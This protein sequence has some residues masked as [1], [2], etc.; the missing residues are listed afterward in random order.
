MLSHDRDDL[1]A[2]FAV[3]LDGFECDVEWKTSDLQVELETCDTVGCASDLE[4]HV[5]EVVFCAKDI[6][7]DDVLSDL[8][9]GVLFSNEASGDTGARR[10]DRHTCIHERQA[11]TA[12]GSHRS[13]AVR[14]HDFRDD[15]DCVWELVFGRK[16]WKE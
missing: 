9:V 15:A 16:N 6:C 8:A 10:R 3:L 7:Q 5:A 11:T 12:D 13:G 4:V 14:A 1:H 2:G